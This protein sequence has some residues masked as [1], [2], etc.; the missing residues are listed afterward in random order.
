MRSIVI[1]DVHG[2]YEELMELFDELNVDSS[3]RIIFVGDLVDKGPQSFRCVSMARAL[4]CQVVL[5]NHEEKYIR[6]AK[7]VAKKNNDP[8]YKIPMQMDGE[9]LELF[10]LLQSE[11]LVGWFG[12]FPDYMRFSTASRNF[13]VVHGGLVPGIRLEDQKREHVIRL[14]YIKPSTKPGKTWDMAPLVDMKQPE[15]SVFWSDK[16][17]NGPEHIIHGHAVRSMQEPHISMSKTAR[18]YAL[19]TG[20]AYGGHLTAMVIEDDQHTFVSVKAR[21]QYAPLMEED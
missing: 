19:D 13:I 15:G 5:G 18:I 1:G 8:S 10:E 11:G 14:R 20:C 17:E 2:C 12:S 9:K 4:K 6:F 7:H 16:W 21:K 3:D